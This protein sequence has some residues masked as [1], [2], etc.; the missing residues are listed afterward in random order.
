MKLSL[1]GALAWSV[2]GARLE[3]KGSSTAL[4]E[5]V[6]VIRR[7]LEELL[8]AST[9]QRAQDAGLLGEARLYRRVGYREGVHPVSLSV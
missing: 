4:F 9:R 1:P 5:Y 3:N 8:H 6:L 7:N 2:V